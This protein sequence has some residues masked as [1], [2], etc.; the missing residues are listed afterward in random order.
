M[1]KTFP[2]KK[3]DVGPVFKNPPSM[4]VRTVVST[5]MN[6]KRS[7]E[8]TSAAFKTLNTLFNTKEYKINLQRV[9]DCFL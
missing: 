1:M 2:A 4:Y 6:T 7:M 9:P 5:I 3:V 8:E